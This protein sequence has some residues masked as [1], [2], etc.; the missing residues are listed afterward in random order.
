MRLAHSLTYVRMNPSLTYPQSLFAKKEVFEACSCNTW[1]VF[2]HGTP[3]PPPPPTDPLFSPTAR[4]A[5]IYI[6]SHLKF[7]TFTPSL[8]TSCLAIHSTANGANSFVKFIFLQSFVCGVHCEESIICPFSERANNCRR[9][10]MFR[11]DILKIRVTSWLICQITPY[12]PT[13]IQ[14]SSG[15][16]MATS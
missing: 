7:Q 12:S 1:S 16:F 13:A 15:R 8:P 9:H 6:C 14:Q 5:D 2:V 10:L 4:L 3:L 11:Y